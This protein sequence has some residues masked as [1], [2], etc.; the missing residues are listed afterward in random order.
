MIPPDLAPLGTFF[1]RFSDKAGSTILIL[2]SKGRFPPAAIPGTLLMNRF[3]LYLCLFIFALISFAWSLCSIFV[4]AQTSSAD[5]SRGKYLVEELARCSEY[6]TPR[7][8]AG[9]LKGAAWL[10]GAP[11]WIKPIA[12]I[13]EWADRTPPLAGLPSM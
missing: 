4:N 11:I 8:D 5:I 6:H 1:C 7:D 9:N 13:R 3:Q 10:Q 2:P 12:L